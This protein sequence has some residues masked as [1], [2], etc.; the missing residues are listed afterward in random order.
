MSFLNKVTLITGGSSGIGRETARLFAQE[1][2]K[3]LVTDVNK[4]GGL[5]TVALIKG[6]GGEATFLPVDVTNSASVQAS[7]NH[8]LA[9]Y[10]AL[11]YAVNSAGI[12]G[13][14]LNPITLTEE[15]TFDNVMDVNVKG[16]W[17][18]M[19]AQI[20]AIMES[21]GGAIVNLASVAGLIGA[22]GGAAYSA[23]KHAVIGLTRAV[24]LEFARHKVRVNAVCP[25]YIDTPM[26]S[27]ISAID[28]KTAQRV[29]VASPM[30]RLGTPYEVAS[31][32][33]YLCGDGASFINGTTL[34]IDGGLTAS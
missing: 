20:P 15:S 25:S 33:L 2:A 16:V 1:G 6:E 22:P 28:E 18:C 14:M 13:T 7:V 31:A 17:L 10:G 9:H 11:H 23:S 4:E 12:S 8:A 26:V 21:G 5:S 3:V 34:A 30:K 19:R 32:I 24:A 27:G 29:Q